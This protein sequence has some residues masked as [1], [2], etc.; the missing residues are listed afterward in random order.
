M[1]TE[2][3]VAFVCAAGLA[4]AG[5]VEGDNVVGGGQSTRGEGPAEGR[6]AGAVKENECGFVGV[7]AGFV[8]GHVQTLSNTHARLRTHARAH[9]HAHTR[10][11]TAPPPP[12]THTC[13][14]RG[15]GGGG[16]G[17]EGERGRRGAYMQ[18]VSLPI[19]ISSREVQYL[20]HT[21][22]QRVEA[23]VGAARL[24]QGSAC[25]LGVRHHGKDDG[26]AGLARADE[27]LR[28]LLWNLLFILIIMHHHRRHHQKQPPRS[29]AAAAVAAAASAPRQ[30]IPHSKKK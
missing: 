27:Q 6:V 8:S 15:A 17:D 2:T 4:V 30:H 11:R 10:A 18:N 3:P 22:L 28:V 5:Q 13:T 23:R 20:T 25:L 21:S 26:A 19:A 14:H 24:P 7:G 9:T 12:S 29:S 1:L 16:G